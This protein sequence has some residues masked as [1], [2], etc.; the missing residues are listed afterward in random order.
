M[1][2][3]FNRGFYTSLYIPPHLSVFLAHLPKLL[4]QLF[5]SSISQ[6]PTALRPSAYLP[7]S[8]SCRM[9]NQFESAYFQSYTPFPPFFLAVRAV[10][11]HPTDPLHPVT[12]SFSAYWTFTTCCLSPKLT[13]P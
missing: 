13:I 3:F 7:Y 11:A 9:T 4:Y 2:I 1:M 5:T 12:Q 8:K 6:G 10:S